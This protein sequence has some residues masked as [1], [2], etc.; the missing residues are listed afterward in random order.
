LEHP[1]HKHLILRVAVAAL[2][3]FEMLSACA[4]GPVH[5]NDIARYL[6]GL[7]PAT[8]SPL[9]AAMGSGWRRHAQQIDA[10]WAAFER[11]QLRHVRSWSA[12]E[13]RAPRST[14][15]YMF[16]GPDFVH[17]DAFF[18]HAATYV[19]SGLEPIGQSPQILA[20]QE[21]GLEDSLASLRQS[22]SHFLEF[23][24]FITS[25]MGKQFKAGQVTGTLPVLY[26]F[27]ARLGKT[28]HQVEFVTLDGNGVV[29]PVR[30]KRKPTG[31]K[32]S[33]VGSDRRP[34]ALYYFRTNLENANVA[35]SRFLRF[36]DRLGEGD[37]LVKSASYLLHLGGFSKVRDFLLSHSAVIVEDDSGI[38][39]RYLSPQHWRLSVFG[40][41]VGPIPVFKQHYQPD[42]ADLFRSGRARPVKF[43]IGYRWYYQHTNIL[44]AERRRSQK[45]GS[46]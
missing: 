23:G 32:I 29:V 40:R 33:F 35:K 45:R 18:P 34:R 10:R 26:V 36:C 15:F 44:I 24:Y 17:A 42:L 11:R 28:I 7:R 13:L 19:L 5:P 22:I 39:L 25:Q 43:G 8:S 6:A 38:P 16:G 9:S 14:M 20:L 31:V 21:S 46:R 30:G 3:I 41:Y 1:K 27:L 37:S 4:A 2:I 12:A